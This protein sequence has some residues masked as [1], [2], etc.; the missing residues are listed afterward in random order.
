[1]EIRR[2][3]RYVKRRNIL[4]ISRSIPFSD[5]LLFP[6]RNLLFQQ[7]SL[8]FN[9]PGEKVS[10]CTL[11]KQKL[12]R[13]HKHNK[14]LQS[15]A[16]SNNAD[17]FK[18]VATSPFESYDSF[19]MV[20]PIDKEA[21]FLVQDILEHRFASLQ[22]EIIPSIRE[23]SGALQEV[24]KERTL[25]GERFSNLKHHWAAWTYPSAFGRPRIDDETPVPPADATYEP[26]ESNA[27]NAC[28]RESRKVWTSF[29]STLQTFKLDDEDGAT[30]SSSAGASYLVGDFSPNSKTETR[31]DNNNDNKR[32][33][34]FVELGRG[35][36]I[37]QNNRSL[38]HIKNKPKCSGETPR[39]AKP[40]ESY[41]RQS[42]RCWKSLFF[43]GDGIHEAEWDAVVNHFTN[44][45]RSQKVLN[46]VQQ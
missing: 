4:S 26:G 3:D 24:E 25:L 28:F 44:S 11:H 19:A 12:F 13:W 8:W 37:N 5:P 22:A 45:S 42:E 21:F 17:G 14:S 15:K 35:Q 32:L 36:A 10:E 2:F 20:R 29:L 23:R 16:T 34:V 31:S 38:P 46:I 7:V 33:S 27:T 9:V 39:M 30:K 6:F 41:A 40:K 1:M 43:E 18:I